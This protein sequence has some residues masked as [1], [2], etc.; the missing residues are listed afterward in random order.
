MPM[1]LLNQSPLSDSLM[2]EEYTLTP[3]LLS[4]SCTSFAPRSICSAIREYPSPIYHASPVASVF[5]SCLPISRMIGDIIYGLPLIAMY[6]SPNHRISKYSPI[7]GFA[8]P[9]STRYAVYK[10]SPAPI[11]SGT[12]TV[13]VSASDMMFLSTS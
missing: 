13:V 12:V 3:S 4:D 2:T 9:D 11:K 8:Y 5:L 1:Q 6:F 10:R 7:S